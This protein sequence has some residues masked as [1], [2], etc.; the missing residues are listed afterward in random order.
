MSGI[1]VESNVKRGDMSAR[2]RC[3]T[4]RGRMRLNT[5]KLYRSNTFSC[6]YK[7]FHNKLSISDMPGND[8]HRFILSD[9]QI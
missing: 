3:F 2:L 6:D 9:R 5:I 4:W 8:K 1:H 7:L